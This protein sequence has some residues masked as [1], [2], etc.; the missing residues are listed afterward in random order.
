MFVEIT[1][2]IEKA[3]DSGTLLF[4]LSEIHSLYV[5]RVKDLGINKLVNKTRLKINLLKHFPEA[6]YYCFQRRNGKMLK[7]ALK[8]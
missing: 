3:V 2:Y 4:K 5:N 1:N 7:E 6:H 8:K